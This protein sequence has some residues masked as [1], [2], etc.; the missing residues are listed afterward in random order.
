M[1]IQKTLLPLHPQSGRRSEKKQKK[2]IEYILVQYL[3]YIYRFGEM[4]EWLKPV[5]C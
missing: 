5:V 2:K 3:K 1:H 4:G